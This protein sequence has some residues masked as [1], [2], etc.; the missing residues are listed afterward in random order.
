MSMFGDY[1]SE[2]AGKGIVECE[3]GFMSFVEN[4]DN[5]Y[6]EDAFVKPDFR[7]QKVAWKMCDK[8]F[9][10]AKEKGKKCVYTSIIPEG[11]RGATISMKAC[12]AYGFEVFKATNNFIA[13][14]KEV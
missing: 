14:K 12:L 6:I 5:L 10:I 2:R 3:H 1:I 13:L 7:K 8:V 4:E 9:E 11:T